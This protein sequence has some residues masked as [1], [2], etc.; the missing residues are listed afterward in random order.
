MADLPIIFSAPMVRALLEGRKTQTR[1]VLKPQP[2]PVGGPFYRPFPNTD[3][4]QWHSVSAAGLIVNIQT[5]PYATGD[6]LY[7]REAFW[8]CD[9]CGYR[10][11][12]ADG[13]NYSGFPDRGCCSSCDALL[14]K[15]KT[16]PIH[17]PR[18]ASRL[19]LTVTDVCVQRLQDTSEADAVA[20]GIERLKSGR[21]FYDPT[22]SHGVV[23]AGH[24]FSSAREA[25]QTLWNSVHGPDAWDANPWIAAYSFTVQRGNIDQIGGAA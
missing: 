4:R 8:T 21:G 7:V 10:N 25:F 22:M 23:R 20:E 15:A 11:R 9:E 13:V 12:C 2:F 5:V 1:R 14:P 24:Y 19:T 16:S 3:P 17:M 18:W 6:R